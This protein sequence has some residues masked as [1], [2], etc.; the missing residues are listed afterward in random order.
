MGFS[1][2]QGVSKWWEFFIVIWIFP[3]LTSWESVFDLVPAV[4]SFNSFLGIGWVYLLISG[5]GFVFQLFII[6]CVVTTLSDSWEARRVVQYLCGRE[7]TRYENHI[8]QKSVC[9]CFSTHLC[10]NLTHH[11]FFNIYFWS[12]FHN[13]ENLWHTSATHSSFMGDWRAI[14]I[15]DLFHVEV[16]CDLCSGARP[17]IFSRWSML[18]PWLACILIL[19]SSVPLFFP[20]EA[21]VLRGHS[22][23]KCRHMLG[24]LCRMNRGVLCV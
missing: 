9:H 13:L 16:Q 5:S 23:A 15:C 21:G 12:G 17:C 7:P 3:W 20:Q 4:C 22:C 18:D 14:V 8:S 10:N 11:C 1:A 6:S 2:V 19:A 24:T